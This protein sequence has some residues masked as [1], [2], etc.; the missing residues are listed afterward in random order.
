[1][2]KNFALLKNCSDEYI[3]MHPVSQKLLKQHLHYNPD[4]GVAQWITGR[5]KGLDGKE[6]GYKTQR[7]KRIVFMNAVYSFPRLIHL[8][9]TGSFP[10]G[11]IRYKNGDNN[12]NRWENLHDSFHTGCLKGNVRKKGIFINKSGSYVSNIYKNGK[13]IYLGSYKNIEDAELSI[14]KYLDENHNE[15]QKHRTG[16]PLRCTS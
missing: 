8:Y 9:M 15:T 7:G 13:T 4:T 12:D 6:A 3:D 11:K 14:K 10:K 16:S 2:Y 5:C 1:M